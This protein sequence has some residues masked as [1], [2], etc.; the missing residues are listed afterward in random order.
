MRHRSGR[1]I[2]TMS[3]SWVKELLKIQR[4]QF[5][6]VHTNLAFQ[7]EP[8]SGYWRK[9]C[10]CN[11]MAKWTIF[12][13]SCNIKKCWPE[14]LTK[15]VSKVYTNKQQEIPGLKTKIT[16]DIAKIQPQ[17]CNDVIENVIKGRRVWNVFIWHFGPYLIAIFIRNW[18]VLKER[19][20][21]KVLWI[22]T[23]YKL[24]WIG[25]KFMRFHF[26]FFNFDL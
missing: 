10:N 3:E 17:L 11:W 21:Y 23:V 24:L 14:L 22:G 19:S 2:E 16:G 4:L 26:F 12:F 1:S 8:C 5:V 20:V 7:E 15:I 25:S 18:S 9:V 13:V 6:I